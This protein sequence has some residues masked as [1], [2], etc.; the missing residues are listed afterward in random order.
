ML[1]AL[2]L[3]GLAACVFLQM[4]ALATL[5]TAIDAAV[6]SRLVAGYNHRIEAREARRTRL[7]VFEIQGIEF[8]RE[9]PASTKFLV[10]PVWD[11]DVPINVVRF[12]ESNECVPRGNCLATIFVPDTEGETSG[13]S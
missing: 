6:I 9:V 8:E 1:D 3:L 5:I 13:E 7:V 2:A 10:V 11:D 4:R 12:R